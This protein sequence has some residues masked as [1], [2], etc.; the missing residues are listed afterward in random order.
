LAVV[1]ASLARCV[2]N[3]LVILSSVPMALDTLAKDSAV[4][5]ARRTQTYWKTVHC[6]S[7]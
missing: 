2:F 6:Q 4:S 7:R 5:I 1:E 3:K